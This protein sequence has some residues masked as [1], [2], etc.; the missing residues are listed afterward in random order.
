MFDN[1]GFSIIGFIYLIMLMLPNLLWTKNKPKGYD[2]V[3]NNEN[4]ILLLFERIGQI[5]TTT[6][7]I[8]FSN[9]SF[10]SFNVWHIWLIVSFIFML[11]YELSWLNYFKSSK[12]IGDF[13]GKFCSIPVPLAILPVLGFL[14][15][16]IYE[17]NILIVISVLILGIGHIGIHINHY[18]E[19]IKNNK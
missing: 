8:I 5:L 7:V 19:Y 10:S 2:K 16:G 4:K 3:S 1:L 17:K 12:N 18:K 14:L 13:Y 9:F 11:L 15:L 6:T